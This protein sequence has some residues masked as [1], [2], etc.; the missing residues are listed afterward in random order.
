MTVALSLPSVYLPTDQQN[1]I[2]ALAVKLGAYQGANLRQDNYYRGDIPLRDLGIAV[3]P[4]LQ[5]MTAI[6]GWPGTVVDVLKERL[7]FLGWDGPDALQQ[8]F[9]DN[10]L[11]VESGF[12]H[13]DSLIYGT[14]FAAVSSGSDGEPDVLV[15]VESPRHMTANFSVRTRRVSEA[16]SIQNDD[17]DQPALAAWYQPNE[18][19]WLERQASGWV[20][21]DRDQHNLGR[22][23]VVQ[24][25][26]RPR[27]GDLGGR[28]EITPAIRSYTDAAVRTMANAEVA[29]EFFAAP[30]RWVMGA[31][32][33]F[34]LDEDGN[35]RS[36]WESY[37]GRILAIEADEDGNTPSVGTFT[38][39]SLQDYF[40][41]V[42]MLSQLVAAEGAMPASYLGFV[43]D[44]PTSA[45]AIRQAEARLV[46]RAEERQD[47]FG[48]GW[49]EVAQLCGLIG[50]FDAAGAQP[51]WRDA[52]TPTRAADAD[53]AV[54]LAGSEFMDA[55]SDVARELAGFTPQQI[56]RLKEDDRRLTVNT[57]RANLAAA[58]A[59]ASQD[60]VVVDLASRRGSNPS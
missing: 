46:K 10:H 15:T 11:N 29:R 48:R 14:G 50:G 35:P 3:P 24:L 16:L 21:V 59:K 27:S 30:Q 41:F 55:R 9:T 53:R 58:A 33:S 47:V 18:T 49:A 44:N 12:V 23:P 51:K 36:A 26:N 32:E 37:I 57:A 45:D 4:N 17:L 13:N 38:P 54:K 31:P 60:P 20:V 5:N 28:S 34:F 7:T 19:V 25:P 42:R 52:A 43:T 8:V 22:V 6:V 2:D 56:A 1:R 40:G 39:G